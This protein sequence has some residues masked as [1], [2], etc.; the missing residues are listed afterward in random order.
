MRA[1]TA[2]II[3]GTLRHDDMVV[4]HKHPS[5]LVSSVGVGCP[6]A[7]VVS[8]TTTTTTTGLLILLA[9]FADYA[10]RR[11]RDDPRFSLQHVVAGPRPGRVHHERAF[12][13]PRPRT[14][15]CFRVSSMSLSPHAGGDG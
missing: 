15:W 1:A 11:H 8:N 5:L 9:S 13:S 2:F 14:S 3:S 4:K 7:V 10:G 6:G 12:A